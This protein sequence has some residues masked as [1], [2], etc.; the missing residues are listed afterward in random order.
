MIL[1][2]PSTLASKPRQILN[3]SAA[4]LITVLA[5]FITT[6]AFSEAVKKEITEDLQTQKLKGI[7]IPKVDLFNT[8]MEDS[9]NFLVHLSRERDTLSTNNNEKGVNVALMGDFKNV[10]ISL[11]LTNIPLENALLY[12]ADLGQA[13]L[14]IKKHVVV[15]RKTENKIA[16]SQTPRFSNDVAFTDKTKSPIGKKLDDLILPSVQFSD[17]PLDQAIAFIQTR[18]VEL[19][20][21]SPANSKGINFILDSSDKMPKVSLN[22]R[23]I[24]IG[25]LISL[26]AEAAGFHLQIDE[27]AVMIRSGVKK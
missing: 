20:V 24:P 11:K 10:K 3:W 27:H 17:T 22:L 7:I 6:L 13:E 15:I 25:D 23:N 4:S 16:G 12:V 26:T 21:D 5:F 9:V 1:N 8:S 19:D 2:N 18:S 14:E